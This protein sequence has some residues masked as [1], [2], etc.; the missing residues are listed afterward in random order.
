MGRIFDLD[1]PVMNFLNKMA[2]LIGLNLLAAICCIPIFTIGASMTAL[3]YVALKIVRNEEGY[4]VKGFFKSFKENF[5]QATIIWLILLAV[6]FI[7]L[8]DLII[9]IYSGINF[10]SWLKIVLLVAAILIVFATMHVF[11]LLSRF[12]N[13]VKNTYKNSL[14][15]G[16]LAFPKTIL[17]MVCWVIPVAIAIFLP[18]L[19][20]VVFCFGISGPAVLCAMLYNGTFKRFEPQEEE[21]ADEWFIEEE[22]TQEGTETGV[23]QENDGIE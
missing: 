18:Q 13:S 7:L 21:E 9:F 5:K 1:S 4:I 3:H 22:E 10:P 19:M 2:D 8:G 11:P 14:L 20:P 16:I 6:M 17:M 23:M 15:M 12:E